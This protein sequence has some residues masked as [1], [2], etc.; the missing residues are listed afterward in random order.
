MREVIAGQRI[1]G[2]FYAYLIVSPL[3]P[4]YCTAR[5]CEL[6]LVAAG[7]SA[8]AAGECIA[9]LVREFCSASARRGAAGSHVSGRLSVAA[10]REEKSLRHPLAMSMN[11]RYCRQQQP[12]GI[13]AAN[14]P[15]IFRGRGRKDTAA[16][17]AC[18]IGHARTR[19]E[20]VEKPSFPEFSRKVRAARQVL[21]QV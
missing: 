1:V 17:S 7:Q 19:L 12:P 13:G 3:R 18:L 4:R 16:H 15:W 11:C 20:P 10:G 14:A 6:A 5:N 21:P 9:L 2:K 8:S